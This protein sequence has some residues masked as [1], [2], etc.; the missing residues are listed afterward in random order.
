MKTVK[1]TDPGGSR[2]GRSINDPR[3]LALDIDPAAGQHPQ[4]VSAPVSA[5]DAIH[6]GGV[7]L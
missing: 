2:G 4:Y 5:A 3:Q 7:E 6:E 1:A